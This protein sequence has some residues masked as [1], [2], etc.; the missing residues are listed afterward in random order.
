MKWAIR[1]VYNG[2]KSEKNRGVHRKARYR[3]TGHGEKETPVLVH[4][5]DHLQEHSS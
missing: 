4:R 5:P 1:Y 3:R 2:G